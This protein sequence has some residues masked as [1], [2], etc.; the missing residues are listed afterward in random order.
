[1][2]ADSLMA[3]A[4]AIGA[5]AEKLER[6]VR[7]YNEA[8]RDGRAGGLNPPRTTRPITANLPIVPMP[9][10]PPPFY[11]D[12]VCGGIT[13][14]MGGVSI[15]EHARV[16]REDGVPVAGLYAAGSTTGWL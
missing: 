4:R 2:K 12:P 15:D 7:A 5:S 8:L 1:H 10:A 3:L 6:T 11:A 16:L 13:Y 9:V 14:T